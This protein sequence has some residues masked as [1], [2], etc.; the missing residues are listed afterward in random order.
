MVMKIIALDEFNE[1]LGESKTTFL[2]YED[3]L[4]ELFIQLG[5]SK[6]RLSCDDDELD[7]FEDELGESVEYGPE[8]LSYCQTRR[9]ESGLFWR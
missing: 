5:E 6:P 7:E 3:E 4:D 8:V 2:S 9:V 1:E